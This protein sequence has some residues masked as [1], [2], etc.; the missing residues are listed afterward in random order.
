MTKGDAKSYEVRFIDM[1][2]HE[3]SYGGVSF[4]SREKAIA[5]AQ[6]VITSFLK[7]DK[8]ECS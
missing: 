7:Q 4:P 5:H 2:E 3:D 6:G 1:C 8:Y